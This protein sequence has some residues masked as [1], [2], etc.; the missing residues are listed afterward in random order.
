MAK[1]RKSSMRMMRNEDELDDVG[2]WKWV[3]ENTEKKEE[4]G[5]K[6][7]WSRWRNW[8]RRKRKR[9]GEEEEEDE[10]EEEEEEERGRGGRRGG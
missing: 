8:S 6:R 1:R 9:G 7:N 3:S 4:E 5:M 10:E 2:K